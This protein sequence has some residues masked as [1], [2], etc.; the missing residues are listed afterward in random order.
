MTVHDWIGGED[1]G[2]RL[3]TPDQ[4]ERV[5]G[6]DGKSYTATTPKPPVWVKGLGKRNGEY[7]YV[8]A[9]PLPMPVEA[10]SGRWFRSPHLTAG[11]Q[12]S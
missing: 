2:V 5:I 4:P 11:H 12:V 3:R 10:R 7:C 1:A 8:A 9:P 6:T